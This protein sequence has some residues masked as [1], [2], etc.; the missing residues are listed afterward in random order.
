MDVCLL[1]ASR[2]TSFLLRPSFCDAA[3]SAPRLGILHRHLYADYNVV[4]CNAACQSMI[5]KSLENKGHKKNLNCVVFAKFKLLDMPDAPGMSRFALGYDRG[6][7]KYLYSCTPRD[8]VMA[9]PLS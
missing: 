3:L 8:T 1:P 9:K 4:F 7:Q 2:G 6:V 5:S